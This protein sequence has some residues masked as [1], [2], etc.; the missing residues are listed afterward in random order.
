M[1]ICLLEKLFCIGGNGS[2]CCI[3]GTV[4]ICLLDFF[5]ALVAMV[6][7]VAW[8]EQWQYASVIYYI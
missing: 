8:V 2:I 5:F 6:A 7:I 1:A 4:A 3:G